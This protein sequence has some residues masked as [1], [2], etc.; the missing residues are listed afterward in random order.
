MRETLNNIQIDEDRNETILV[1]IYLVI[2]SL[3]DVSNT[4]YSLLDL[5]RSVFVP[6]NINCWDCSLNHMI[7]LYSFYKGWIFHLF[8]AVGLRSFYLEESAFSS[9]LIGGY[10]SAFFFRSSASRN[11]CSSRAL[12]LALISVASSLIMLYICSDDAKLPKLTSLNLYNIGHKIAVKIPNTTRALF[13][14][15][16]WYSYPFWPGLRL[17]ESNQPSPLLDVYWPICVLSLEYSK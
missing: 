10:N 4:L 8:L 13:L 17:A 1:S 12:T 2:D 14:I 16:C 11:M 9:N 5:R 6:K 15:F 3:R 7:S